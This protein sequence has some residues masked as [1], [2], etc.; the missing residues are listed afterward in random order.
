MI[1]KISRNFVPIAANLYKIRDSKD[2]AGDL[3]RSA[4][5]QKAQYQGFWILTPEGK[6]LSAHHDHSD[7]RW[8]EE[9]LAAIDEAI[10][11]AGPI[12][13]R[14]REPKDVLPDWGKGVQKDGRVTLAIWTRYFFE[15]R[16]IATGAIDAV[17]WSAKEWQEFAPP[18]PKAKSWRIP[19]KMAVEFSRCLST[20]SDKSSM[21]TP[22]EVTEVDLNGSVSRVQDG[23]ATLSYTGYI[24]ALHTEPFNKKYVH[25]AKATLRGVGTY[26]IAKKEMVS[27]LWIFE[28]TTRLVEETSPHPLAAV[29]E[30]RRN[31][32]ARKAIE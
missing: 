7:K 6:L 15:G 30:W 8:T 27:L 17:T 10:E 14:N 1:Q 22:E 11:K 5:K 29:V 16:G 24:A 3:F 25:T 26:D 32:K 4:Q 12:R 9:V 13:P 19:A 21:P 31:A 18:D 23:I 2:A 20:V 28:G